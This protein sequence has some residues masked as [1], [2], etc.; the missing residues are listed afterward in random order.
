M[1]YIVM[2]KT[3]PAWE[4]GEKPNK[5][6]IAKVGALMGELIKEK[7]LVGGDGLRQSSLGVRVKRAGGKTTR[8]NGPF[9]GG[10]ERPAGFVIYRAETLDDAVAFA[11][12]QAA[13]LGDG[14]EIDVRPV[15][16][17]WDIGLGAPPKPMPP[18]R[19][20][21]L[22]KATPA[23]EAGE[24][25]AKDALAKLE[26]E[27]TAKGALVTS[28]TLAPSK[29]GRRYKNSKEGVRI[30]DGPFTESK[31]LVAGFVLIEATSIDDAAQTVPRYMEIVGTNE[32]AVRELL[33]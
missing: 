5:E 14:A 6:L 29:R 21:A 30:I 9:T 8:E 24:S 10:N 27:L 33:D 13:A 17:A 2:H 15:T 26:G 7:R 23:T 16:E 25:P 3:I 32:V 1:K 11:E 22:R 18:T 31:E 19:W 12:K 20:M 4:R 28:A